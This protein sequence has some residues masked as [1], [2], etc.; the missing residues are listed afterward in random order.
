[1]EC[2]HEF[3]AA[4]KRVKHCAAKYAMSGCM[5]QTIQRIAVCKR[6]QYR[7]SGNGIDALVTQ[8]GDALDGLYHTT[9]HCILGGTVFD[10]FI[11]G[12]ELMPALH[13]P[14]RAMYLDQSTPPGCGQTLAVY[15]K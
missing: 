1:M 11:R 14:L 12:E 10:T 13:L 9:A 2:G 4:N 3:L 5:V 8:T 6:M 15:G 7:R